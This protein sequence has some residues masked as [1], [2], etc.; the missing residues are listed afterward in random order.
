M[1]NSKNPVD[2]DVRVRERNLKAGLLRKDE[3]DGY[4]ASLPDVAALAQPVDVAQPGTPGEPAAEAP[5]VAVAPPAPKP[6][7]M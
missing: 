1:S 2:Y 5:P 4:L 3:V 6:D 7:G